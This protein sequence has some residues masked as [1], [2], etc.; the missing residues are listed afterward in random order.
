MPPRE[1]LGHCRIVKIGDS[2][3]L[4]LPTETFECESGDTLAIGLSSSGHGVLLSL[5]DVAKTLPRR[6][7][8]VGLPTGE[9]TPTEAR[10]LAG[11]LIRFATA[12]HQKELEA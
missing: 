3:S 12:A 10:Y 4:D 11:R 7:G 2:Q 9:L 1:R 6:E 8:D 5:D